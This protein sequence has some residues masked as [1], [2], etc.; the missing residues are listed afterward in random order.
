MTVEVIGWKGT[1]EAGGGRDALAYVDSARVT[2]R[3][4]ADHV[5][6]TCAEHGT[7]TDDPNLCHHT[8]ALAATPAPIEKRNG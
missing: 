3:R 5:T 7:G 2:I 1:P 4:R 6:W 8:T